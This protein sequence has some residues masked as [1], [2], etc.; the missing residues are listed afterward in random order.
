MSHELAD[1]LTV[2]ANQLLQ[3][4]QFSDA[5]A[6]LQRAVAVCPDHPGAWKSLGHALLCLGQPHE[7]TRAFDRAVG[8]RPDSATALW[9]GAVAHA[10]V[11]N[12]VV[13]QNYLRRTLQ[14]Q[15]TWL[16]MA[17][18]VPQLAVFLQLSTVTGDLLHAAFGAYA[19]RTYRHAGDPDRTIEVVRVVGQ[20]AIGHT[21]YVTLGLTNLPTEPGKP[22]LELIL[23]TSV[24]GEV[25]GD[26]LAS[27][28]FHL[29]DT[30]YYPTPGTIVR[31]VVAVLG[32]GDLS[33]RLPH[34][35]VAVPRRWG[36][37]L[38][39]DVGPPP[40][41]LAQAIPV[42]EAEYLRWRAGGAASLER[43]WLER[44]VEVLDLRRAGNLA[45]P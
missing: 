8:L 5:V 40:I 26:I 45:P 28:A 32:A 6:R 4:Q 36:L 37:R 16:E 19:G 17:R 25:C 20:P 34:I 31:D 12:R 38:P 29:W 27:A 2:E 14:L 21:T 44:G 11:G 39:L 23:G 13:A 1:A 35:Y 18:G 7:A 22:R 42:S 24:D 30:R 43:D 9:G 15:P 41:S 10:E 3:L 33:T